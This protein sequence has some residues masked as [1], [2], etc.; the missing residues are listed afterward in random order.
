MCYIVYK[1]YINVSLTTMLTVHQ[2]AQMKST[3]IIEL[4]CDLDLVQPEK[5]MYI[6]YHYIKV[7]R[8]HKYI[9]NDTYFDHVSLLV[10]GGRGVYVVKKS[11]M[12]IFFTL[13]P[14][15]LFFWP[16]CLHPTNFNVFLPYPTSKLPY[17]FFS[18]FPTLLIFFFSSF[19][20]HPTS[21]KSTPSV[22]SLR[23][24]W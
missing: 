7:H 2:S 15:S 14:I 20:P 4:L 24:I 10:G 21:G 13:C 6:L 17:P 1:I 22:C 18:F 9:R 3:R 12:P 16:F 8:T 19:F 23:N 11:Y 5:V